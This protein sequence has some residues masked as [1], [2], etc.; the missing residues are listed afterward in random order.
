MI[1][2]CKAACL[3]RIKVIIQDIGN[4]SGESHVNPLKKKKPGNKIVTEW[5]S[6]DVG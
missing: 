2:K 4:S 1:M 5:D 3:V 6:G